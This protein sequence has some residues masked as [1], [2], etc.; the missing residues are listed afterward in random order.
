MEHF[1][2]QRLIVFFR[3]HR[4]EDVTADELVHD[5]AI[6]GEAGEDDVFTIQ[7]DHHVLHLP[8]DIPCLKIFYGK[9]NQIEINLKS[10]YLHGVVAPGFDVIATSDIHLHDAIVSDAQQTSFLMPVKL[11]NEQG[12]AILRQTL[13]RFDVIQL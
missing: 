5:F 3:A 7:L 1:F 2:V 11:N 8:V 6:A 10:F 9:I 4:H 12:N 13:P